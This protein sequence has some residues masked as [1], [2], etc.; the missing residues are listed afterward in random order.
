M[1][2]FLRVRFNKSRS[3]ANC[4]LLLSDETTTTTT[5]TTTTITTTITTTTTTEREKKITKSKFNLRR[6]RCSTL[7][8]HFSKATG[9]Y[10]SFFLLP[11]VMLKWPMMWLMYHRRR[12]WQWWCRRRRSRRTKRWQARRSRRPSSVSTIIGIII[13]LGQHPLQLLD[14]TILFYKLSIFLA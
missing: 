2:F 9:T 5:T 13:V 7:Y 3:W 4:V 10:F 14:L 6:L 8:K 1:I 12:G 11:Y